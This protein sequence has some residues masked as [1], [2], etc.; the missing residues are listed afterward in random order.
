MHPN[1]KALEVFIVTITFTCLQ[2]WNVIGQGSGSPTLGEKQ[3]GHSGLNLS[4]FQSN[5]SW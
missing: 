4:D 5:A 2:S 1:Q 3:L